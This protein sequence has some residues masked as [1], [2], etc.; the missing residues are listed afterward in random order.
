MTD[1]GG[2][3]LPATSRFTESAISY[4]GS[5]SSAMQ[6]FSNSA[7]LQAIWVYAGSSQCAVFERCRAARGCL[8]LRTL[9]AEVDALYH[10]VPA[11]WVR[12]QC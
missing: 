1:S 6:R 10:L 9:V 2:V 5:R 8:S 3:Q 4:Y 7:E 12:G 11:N